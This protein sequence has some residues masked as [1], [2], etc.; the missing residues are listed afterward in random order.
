[1]T[2][3]DLFDY[4]LPTELIAQRPAASRS[5]SRLMTLDRNS[6]AV[7]HHMFEELEGMLNSEDTLALNNTKVIP[8]RL[9]AHRK[10]G[11]KVEILLIRDLGEGRWKAMVRGVSRLKEGEALALGEHAIRIGPR[12]DNGMT[13]VIFSSRAGAEEMI[14]TWGQTPLPPY[15]VRPGGQ[16]DPEDILRY[17]TVFAKAPGSCA[18][19][20]AGLHFTQA[21]LDRIKDRGVKIVE[22]TLHV[23]PG[24]FR[25]VKCQH[26][27]DHF[28]DP[29]YYQIPEQTADIINNTL[30]G[31]GRVVTVGSTV[32]RAL[33]SAV[34]P[35][36][37][38]APGHGE[39]CLY[40]T[41]GFKFQVSSAMITNFHLPRS[42]LLVMVAAF[43]GRENTMAAYAEAVENK[44]RFFSYGDAIFIS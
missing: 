7:G 24:T 9:M 8:A 13:E 23:G 36:G 25:P 20:T 19:P 11:G 30:A 34:G 42:T 22:V 16:M 26:I 43:A 3:I 12:L 33:E 14:R 6:G 27:E 35:D 2:S 44:Y 5:A 10:S 40:I 1:M 41:P 4:H 15:I 37:R 18:A 28:M 21:L 31:G 39:T 17:Q 32:T 29:E 38:V